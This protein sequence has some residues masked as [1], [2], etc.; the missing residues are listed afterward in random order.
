MT[1][2]QKRALMVGGLAG[3]GVLLF[4]GIALASNKSSGNNPPPPPP[5]NGGDQGC[6]TPRTN[7]SDCD[8]AEVDYVVQHSDDPSVSPGSYG[9][10][11][12]PA[13]GRYIYWTKVS[14]HVGHITKICKTAG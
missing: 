1:S 14:A 12:I 4:A 10:V 9:P 8:P 13:S 6:F 3:V 5:K 7:C 2:G 11:L